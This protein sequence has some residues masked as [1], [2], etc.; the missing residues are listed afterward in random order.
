MAVSDYNLLTVKLPNRYKLKRSYCGIE[1]NQCTPLGL[2]HN[3]RITLGQY[4]IMFAVGNLV[5]YSVAPQQGHLAHVMQ[6]FGYLSKYSFVATP[7]D[8]NYINS[9]VTAVHKFQP[10]CDWVEI[11]PGACKD[12]PPNAPKTQLD[13][14]PLQII[15]YVDA[16]HARNTVT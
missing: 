1:G 2:L 6:N 11:F 9:N 14:K 15:C 3:W 12:V 16:D 10:L 13:T 7:F 4:D 5:Q 8:G